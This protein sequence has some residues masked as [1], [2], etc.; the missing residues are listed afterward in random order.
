LPFEITLDPAEPVEAN[1]GRIDEMKVGERVDQR[2]ADAAVELRSLRE[3]G[4]NVVA[5]DK[6]APAFLDDE[7]RADDALVLA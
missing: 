6:P 4:R 7:N 5:D 1:L 2:K 3:F